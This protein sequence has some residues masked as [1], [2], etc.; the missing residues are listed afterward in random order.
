MD[1]LT[2]NVAAGSISKLVFSIT[3]TL[4]SFMAAVQDVDE[5]I[6]TLCTEVSSLADVLDAITTS[7]QAQG[8]RP[9]LT[10]DGCR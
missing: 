3:T 8:L 2:I 10:G 1:P 7:L 9:N 5:T 6:R 4:Y